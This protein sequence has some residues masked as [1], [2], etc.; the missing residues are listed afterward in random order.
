MLKEAK[1]GSDGV[2][3][4]WA[5]N[6]INAM[7]VQSPYDGEISM[8]EFEAALESTGWT[9]SGEPCKPDPVGDAQQF[10][11]ILI[12]GLPMLFCLRLNREC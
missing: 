10:R 2:R 4:I 5:K 11:S 9:D 3:N 12:P 8:L 6:F 1:V 7:D